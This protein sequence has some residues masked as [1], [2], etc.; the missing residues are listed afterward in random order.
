MKIKNIRLICLL[1]VTSI[2]AGISS[3]ETRAQSF[4]DYKKR[5]Q[6]DFRKYKDDKMRKFNEYRDKINAEFAEFM[7]RTWTEYEIEPA[8]PVPSSPEPPLPVVVAPDKDPSNDRLPF[9]KVKPVPQITPQPIPLTPSSLPQIKPQNPSTTNIPPIKTPEE[10]ADRTSVPDILFNYYGRKCSIPFDRSLRF[11]LNDIDENSVAKAWRQLSGDASIKLVEQ[12]IR[13]RD[14]MKLPDWGYFRMVEKLSDAVFP[15]RK[16][17]SV[18]LQMYL[19]TQS[20]YKVRIG[21]RDNRLVVLLPCNEDIYNYCFVPLS[22][23]RY[24]VI[25]RYGKSGSTYIFN[26][27]FPR[28]QMF[29]L[30]LPAQPNLVVA[31]ASL[32]QFKSEYGSGISA[33]IAVNKNLIDFYNDYPLSSNWDINSNASL[34]D[35]VKAQLYPLLREAITDKS[36]SEAANILLRFVQTAFNYKTDDEQFGEERS[37]FPDETFFYPYS[38]CEDRAILYSVLVREL[39]GLDA[40]LVH[41]PGHLATAVRFDESVTG[42]YFNIDGQKFTVC[43]PTYIN[44][45]IGMS[46]PDLKNTSAEIIRL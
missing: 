9:G 37:L 11:S 36:Q 29:S 42:D 30:A 46:M 2:I 15:D 35:D 21:R 18:L 16:N 10:H 38:D 19:L 43:D 20:G 23:V 8:I 4:E 12:C 14:D 27:E 44:S 22:G 34:S 25:D 39:L 28:E 3:T 13:L 45:D 17:E 31:P 7:S 33:D 32:R 41:Y 24:Y 1:S 26:H 6:S 5:A 40:V